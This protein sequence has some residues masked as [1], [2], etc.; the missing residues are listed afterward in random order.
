VSTSVTDTVEVPSPSSSRSRTRPTLAGIAGVLAVLTF[1]LG[2]LGFWTKS[3][4]L[5][6]DTFESYVADV[7]EEPQ[8]TEAIATY[9]VEQTQEVLQLET[10]IEEA[11]PP[12]VVILLGDQLDWIIAGV[13]SLYTQAVTGIV[14]SEQ[15][16]TIVVQAAGTAHAGFVRLLEGDGLLDGVNVDEDRITL[17]LLPLVSRALIAVQER[18]GLLADVEV[19]ELTRDG[20]PAEQQAQLEDAL[21]RDLPDDFAQLTVYEGEQVAQA[22]ESV[23]Q[24][25]RIFA[26][27]T[28]TLWVLVGLGVVLGAVAVVLARRRVRAALAM[29]LGAGVL[30]FVTRIIVGIVAGDIPYEISGPAGRSAAEII[31]TRLLQSLSL[32]VFSFA[33][34]AALVGGGTL[35]VR[36]L[37]GRR[38]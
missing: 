16:Q 33:V 37:Q 27:V 3:T 24:A 34:A 28:R 21:G 23:Q 4:M 29:I 19:P 30:M 1:V 2:T 8:V 32:V 20:D 22:S 38:A 36:W 31:T 10:R 18:F 17:N 35:L 14:E 11:L 13:R 6:T 7:L 26:F 15:F 25:Q 9:V 12:R 5:D